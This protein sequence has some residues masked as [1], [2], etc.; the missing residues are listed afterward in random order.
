MTRFGFSA[1]YSAVS[2]PPYSRP[3]STRSCGSSS[4]P[5]AHMTFWTL[6]EE[7]R[8]QTFSM[9]L[10]AGAPEALEGGRRLGRTLERPPVPAALEENQ[11]PVDAGR[12]PLGKARRDVRIVTAP[13]DEGGPVAARDVV[14]PLL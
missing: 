2:R 11:L 7:V 9:L 1:P 14:L 8:P 13:E 12:E 4:S 6:L 5:I 3:T 10:P